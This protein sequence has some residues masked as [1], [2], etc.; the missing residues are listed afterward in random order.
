MTDEI[1]LLLRL[2]EPRGDSGFEAFW[3]H[4]FFEVQ[5]RLIVFLQLIDVFYF[6]FHWSLKFTLMLRLEIPDF[7]RVPL[8]E[9][10]LFGVKS[11]PLHFNII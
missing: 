2:F 10:E 9:I 8:M 3:I 1:D 11:K 5:P 4:I 6:R 7:Q